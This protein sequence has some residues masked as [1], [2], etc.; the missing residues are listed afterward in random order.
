MK[1]G[2]DPEKS[3]GEQYGKYESQYRRGSQGFTGSL[4]SSLE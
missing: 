4:K 3:P 2:K 1:R